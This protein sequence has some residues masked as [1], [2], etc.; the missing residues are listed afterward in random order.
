VVVVVVVV[1]V[2][3]C[4]GSKASYSAVELACLVNDSSVWNGLSMMMVE[5]LFLAGC[6]HVNSDGSGHLKMSLRCLAYVGSTLHRWM[7]FD[8]AWRTMMETIVEQP[9]FPVIAISPSI[10]DL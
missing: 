5:R 3:A 1:V 7:S 9:D 8:M 10:F 4:L 2:V 6:V